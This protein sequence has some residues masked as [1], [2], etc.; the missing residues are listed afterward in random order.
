MTP[1]RPEIRP[2]PGLRVVRAGDAVLAESA[3]ALEVRLA[4]ESDATIWFP[5]GEAGDL[6]LEPTEERFDIPGLGAARRL[7][8]AAS[9]GPIRGAAWSLERPA[10]GAE[11]LKDRVAFD[12]EQV[13]VERL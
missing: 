5:G 1:D 6:F 9:S 11:A 10:P 4:G 7:V 3:N 12:A 2:A 8:I 13:A